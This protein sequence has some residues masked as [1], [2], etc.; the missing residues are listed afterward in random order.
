MNFNEE[1]LIEEVLDYFDFDKVHKHMVSVNWIWVGTGVPNHQKL[2][3]R[4]TELLK[5]AAQ[6]VKKEFNE[7]LRTSNQHNPPFWSYSVA[8][9]GFEAQAIIYKQDGEF[10]M[11]LRLL[12]ILSQAESTGE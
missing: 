8:T 3:K 1:K 11:S 9:G 2:I 6:A 5:D 4:A 7:D 12:F 10:K